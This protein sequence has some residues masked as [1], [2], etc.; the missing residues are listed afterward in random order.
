MGLEI[1]RDFVFDV[2][3]LGCVF[4]LVFVFFVRV[5]CRVEVVLGIVFFC[6]LFWF[7]SNLVLNSDFI[8]LSF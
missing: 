3:V 1:L 8:L 2:L 6:F 5:S 4:K 7:C